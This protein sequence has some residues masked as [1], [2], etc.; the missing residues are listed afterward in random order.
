MVQKKR[1]EKRGSRRRR[2]LRLPFQP[3]NK[4]GTAPS[5]GQCMET[6]LSKF[7]GA[8]IHDGLSRANTIYSRETEKEREIEKYSS[9]IH[10]QTCRASSCVLAEVVSS[11]R[12]SEHQHGWQQRPEL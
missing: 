12:L 6:S 1:E 2:N 5:V 9:S 11:Q 7:V 10:T 3:S 4:T 8:S